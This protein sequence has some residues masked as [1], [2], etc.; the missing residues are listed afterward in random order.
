MKLIDGLVIPYESAKLHNS[1]EHG[2]NINHMCSRRDDVQQKSRTY[3]R[4]GIPNN[5]RALLFSLCDITNLP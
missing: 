4:N 3:D 5:F 2:Q 1:R